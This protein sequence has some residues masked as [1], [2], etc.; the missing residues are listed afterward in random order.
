[1][2]WTHKNGTYPGTLDLEDLEPI[3]NGKWHVCRKVDAEI[4]K[5]LLKELERE[6]GCV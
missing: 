4:S 3:R 6:V 2:N 1:M 5:E